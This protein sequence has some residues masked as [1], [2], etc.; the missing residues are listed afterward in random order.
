MSYEKNE[1]PNYITNHGTKEAHESKEVETPYV[2][3]YGTKKGGKEVETPYVMGYGTKKGGKEVET[4]YVMSYEKNQRPNYITNYGAKEAHESK[5]VDAPYILGYISARDTKEPKEVEAPYITGYISAQGTKEPKEV[6]AP[7]ITA[8]ISTQTAKEKVG[9][10]CKH[11]KHVNPPSF[12]TKHSQEPTSKGHEHHHMH[13]HSS[14]P[15]DHNG[16]SWQ[17]FFTFDY[18]HKGM[19]MPLNFPNQEHSPFLPKDVADSIPFSTP[20]LP[21]LLQL[22]SIPQGSRDAN[23]MAYALE[24]YEMKPINWETK[25]CA[26][27]LESMTDFV[28]KIIGAG[29]RF[30]ILSTTH[31]I[32]STSITQN[33]ILKEPKEVLASKMVFCHPLAYPYAV[34]FCHH[35]EKDT[36]FFK[37]RLRGENGDKVEAMAVCP[38]DTSDWVPNHNI[39]GLL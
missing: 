1:S 34:F 2:M 29:V 17:G 24:Q 4:P 12:D 16:A 38:M 15:M 23:N 3:G 9:T 6:E 39:F 8:Y 36:K 25:L 7:Y 20:Q 37:V 14:S 18:L 30:N 27:S 32:T 5:E 13:T 21:Q 35:F 19:I 11:H 33:Y 10:K 22:L 31:P 26:T 28:T